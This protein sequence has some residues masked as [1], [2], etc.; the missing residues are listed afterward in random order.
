MRT[1]KLYIIGAGGHAKV[2]I[3]I[4][5]KQGRYEIIGV[6]DDNPAMQG[7]IFFGYQVLGSSSLLLSSENQGFS[8]L[9]AIGDNQSRQRISDHLVATGRA[10]VNA[11][12]PSAQI[13]RNVTIGAGSVV[14]AGCVINADTVIGRNVIINSR[15]SVDHDCI[16][17]DAVHIA[18]GVTLCGDV[19]IGRGSLIGAGATIKPGIHIGA[20]VVIGAGS[21]AVSNVPDGQVFVG[22]P[23]KLLPGKKNAF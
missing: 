12:H 5:E 14:M 17:E 4:L 2:V 15:A 3:D 13:S 1:E 18:P 21:V 22:C 9:V 11:V 20:N 19:K 16:I 8:F 10:L 7:R 6:L 23:A